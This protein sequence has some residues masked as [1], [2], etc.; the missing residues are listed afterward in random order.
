MSGAYDSLTAFTE[1]FTSRF[2]P[3][4]ALH[5]NHSWQGMG[6]ST[7]GTA[8]VCTAVCCVA[9]ACDISKHDHDM[10]ALSYYAQLPCRGLESESVSTLGLP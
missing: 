3:M 10:T 6:R 7:A 8:R 1:L 5:G 2:T 9:S 4:H